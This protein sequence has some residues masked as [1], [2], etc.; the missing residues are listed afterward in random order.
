MKFVAT[1]IPGVILVSPRR[2]TDARGSFSKIFQEK[3]FGEYEMSPKWR[4]A[5]VSTTV[6][7]AVRGLHFQVPPAGHDK[8]VVCV[9]GAVFD[10]ALDIR[11]GSPTYGDHVSA[12]LSA[13]GFDAIYIPSGVAHGFCA[14]E[15][16][17]TLFY[18]TTS[19]H[20]ASLDC[21][22]AWDSAE[23][24]WP[25]ANP[26]LSERDTQHPRLEDFDSPFRFQ[27]DQ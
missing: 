23:I 8:L 1:A 14:L 20:E 12:T 19:I 18:L 24:M 17:A 16:M 2:L 4:E 27:S 25:I 22:I 3:L 6:P 11:V 9:E 13:D 15:G 26:I 10:V 7:N 21:G 5:Y